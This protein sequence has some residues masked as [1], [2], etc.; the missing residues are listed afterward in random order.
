MNARS[1]EFQPCAVIPMYEHAG[2]VEAVVDGLVAAGLPVLIVDDGSGEA[3]AASVA[4]LAR[5]KVGVTLHR[6]ERNGGK[7]AAVSDGLRAASAAGYTHAVQIDADGQHDLGDLPRFLEQ[8]AA[9]SDAVICGL[10]VF[11]ASIPR[12]RYYLRY[13]TH[14]LVWLNTCSTQIRDSMCGFRVYPLSRTVALL[15]AEALG[16]RM[17]FDIEILVRLQWRDTPMVWIPTRV[18]YP[19]DGISHFRLFR[20]NVLIARVH[21]RLFL[22]MLS[23]LPRLLV[24]RRRTRLPGASHA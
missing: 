4:E 12:S 8:A 10:P 15:E 9:S 1:A 23:R 21:A 2:A 14:A 22:G 20:D 5:R 6:R 18:R 16:L 3:C 13:L 7:G 24:R 17:D 19:A 11:D